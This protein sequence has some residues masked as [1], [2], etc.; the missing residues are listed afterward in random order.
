MPDKPHSSHAHPGRQCNYHQVFSQG[1]E[2][3]GTLLEPPTQAHF[4]SL[5]S[6][7]SA[8]N[9]ETAPIVLPLN[10]LM[11]IAPSVVT[12]NDRRGEPN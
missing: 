12:R 10:A 6:M 11:R 1:Y 3:S 8:L 5:L 2:A 7:Y 4:S 9:T